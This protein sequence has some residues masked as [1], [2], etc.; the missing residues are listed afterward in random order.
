MNTWPVQDAKAH[1]SELLNTCL[2]E[3]PQI[4]TRRG[5]EAAVLVSITEWRQLHHAARPSLKSLLLSEIGKT[6]L[7][8]PQRG[9][10]K[11]RTPPDL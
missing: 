4:V 11:R 1:F 9:S 8:L 10:A 5:E 2:N 6:E 7:D 3:G